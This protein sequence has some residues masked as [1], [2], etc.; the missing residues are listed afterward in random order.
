VHWNQRSV[1]FRVAFYGTFW[2]ILSLTA[3]FKERFDPD[4][5]DH[6]KE[7]RGEVTEIFP[8]RFILAGGAK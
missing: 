4:T 2:R 5:P 6:L 7:R 1:R 8:D 3:S